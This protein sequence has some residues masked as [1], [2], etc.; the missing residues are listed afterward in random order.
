MPLVPCHR[1]SR[2]LRPS[3]ARCP[4]CDAVLKAEGSAGPAPQRRLGRLAWFLF[5]ATATACGSSVTV[6]GRDEV[7]SVTSGTAVGAGGHAEGGEAPMGGAGGVPSDGGD[8]G[9]IDCGDVGLLY[10][11]PPPPPPPGCGGSDAD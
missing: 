8:G 10:G 1:C 11:S 3:E 4:F 7:A 2:H 6:D 5:G 9:T